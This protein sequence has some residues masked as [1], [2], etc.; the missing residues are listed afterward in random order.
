MRDSVF[1]SFDKFSIPLA[2]IE[3]IIDLIVDGCWCVLPIL[4]TTIFFEIMS[5]D[6]NI[7]PLVTNLLHG[8]SFHSATRAHHPP[9]RHGRI[10]QQRAL[11]SHINSCTITFS[12]F[13]PKNALIILL[14][15]KKVITLLT[16]FSAS[17]Q[18]HCLS[19]FRI[20]DDYID[21]A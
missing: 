14:L 9:R 19:F 12:P 11:N 1:I 4:P 7:T 3:V 5:V 18:Q 21:L 16:Y 10:L 6:R 8:V 17:Y 2:G 15:S 13:S 20:D